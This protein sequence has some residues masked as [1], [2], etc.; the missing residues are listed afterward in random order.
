LHSNVTVLL[1]EISSKNRNTILI[2]IGINCHPSVIKKVW[3]KL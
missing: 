1:Y 2:Q 3:G